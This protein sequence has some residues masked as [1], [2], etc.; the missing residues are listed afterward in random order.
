MGVDIGAILAADGPLSRRIDGYETRPQQLEMTAAVERAM[1]TQERLLV[2]AGTGV[3][4]SF[5]YLLPAIKRIVEHQER[6]VI[7]TNTITLQEQL[8]EKDIPLLNAVIPEEFTAVLVKGRGNYISLRRLKLTSERQERLCS[9]DEMRGSLHAIEDWAYETTD[10][11]LATLPQLSRPAVWDFVQS[12]S[13]N[14]M[15]KKCPTYQQCFYQA[16]RRRMEHGDLL[17]CNHAIF[18]ADLALR[19]RGVGLL[20][21]YDHVILD[22]AHMIE[23]VASEHFGLRLT[24]GRIR[25]L[26]NLL[27][28][29]RTGRGFLATLN[30]PDGAVEPVDLAIQR[31]LHARDEADAVFDRLSLWRKTGGGANGRMHEADVVENTLSDVMGELGKGL[32]LLRDRVTREADQYELNSYAQRADDI[33]AEA[34]ML[35]SQSIE[36]CVYWMDEAAGPR[37]RSRRELACQPVDVAPILREQLFGQEMSVTLTS[38]T[39]ATGPDDFTHIATRLGCEDAATLQ[40]GSPF[41]HGAQMRVIIDR[42]MPAPN[43]RGYVDALVPRILEHVAATDGGAFVLF[44]GLAMMRQTAERLRREFAG[45]RPLL[46]Q[47]EDGPRS[48]LLQ[49]F[50]QDERT[51]LMGVAS[52]WQGVDVRGR[53]LRNVIITRLPFDVPDRPLIQ[54]RH[55][56]IEARGG[57]PF[58]DDQIPRAVIRFRQGVGRLIRSA[59][60]EGRVVILDPRVATTWYG[61]RFLAALPEGVEPELAEPTDLF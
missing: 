31:S 43:D 39:L 11:S 7:A 44:T 18:F 47:N 49:R 6:V 25:H 26:L 42:Q 41:D 15:G 54:S 14:C 34:R 53:A 4:K 13:H 48:L 45:V 12:D 2:E 8:M 59:T 40:L 16:A 60:D 57:R 29:P 38:A 20:P 10:G 55:E 21:P 27:Y 37:G 17:V 36:G 58:T 5:A 56:R 9:D 32:R 24:E 22:E 3:G 30:L 50:R 52:F 1:D 23:D 51:V 61:K 19:S 46:V 35:I 28:S 33:A